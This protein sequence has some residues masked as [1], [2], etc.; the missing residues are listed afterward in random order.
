MVVALAHWLPSPTLS[1]CTFLGQTALLHAPTTTAAY[2][3]RVRWIGPCRGAVLNR[4]DEPGPDRRHP[5]W[6]SPQPDTAHP[7]TR[8]VSFVSLDHAPL[9]PAAVPQPVLCLPCVHLYLRDS[10]YLFSAPPDVHF[11]TSMC[12]CW[13]SSIF[14][15]GSPSSIPLTG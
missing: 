13:P 2:H 14:Y 8:C 10:P 15:R 12:S 9:E 5:N 6:L 11:A 3:S 4:T 1:V 7:A